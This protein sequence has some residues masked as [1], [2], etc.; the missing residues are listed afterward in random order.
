MQSINQVYGVRNNNEKKNPQISLI[1][2]DWAK[3]MRIYD[4]QNEYKTMRARTRSCV[5]DHI[6]TAISHR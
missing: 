6:G 2:A 5:N 1:L 4:F 3:V